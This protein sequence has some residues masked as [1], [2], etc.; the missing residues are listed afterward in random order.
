MSSSKKRESAADSTALPA[1]AAGL[2]VLEPD[3]SAE[4]GAKSKGGSGSAGGSLHL[5]YGTAKDEKPMERTRL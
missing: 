2:T 3:L 1:Y 5:A 4:L